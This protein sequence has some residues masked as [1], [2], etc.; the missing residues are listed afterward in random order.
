MDIDLEWPVQQ[1]VLLGDQRS[2]RIVRELLDEESISVLMDLLGRW[3]A[4]GV[5]NQDPTDPAHG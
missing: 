3:N 1:R 4:A 5:A 2:E